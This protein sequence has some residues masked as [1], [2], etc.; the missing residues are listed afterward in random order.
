MFS[1]FMLNT[2]IA[3]SIIAVVAGLVGFFVVVRGTAF[4]AHALPLGT[5]P[6]AA[7]AHLLGI[8]DLIGLAGF[9]ALGV[10][11][12]TELGR[13]SRRDVATALCLVT[14]LGLGALFLSLANQYS[15]EVYSL[16]FGEVLA[17][18]SNELLP[19]TI[20]SALPLAA[21]IV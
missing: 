2:W 4:A 17:V 12:I 18:A 7:L 9:A 15:Q 6:G 16:L 3:A 14:L 1:G 8:D 5:F 21:A 20:L 10:L 19:V 13:R 11:G